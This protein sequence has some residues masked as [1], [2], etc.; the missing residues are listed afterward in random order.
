MDNIMCLHILLFFINMTQIMILEI[1][2]Y[3][4]DLSI[5]KF[6]STQRIAP[7]Y[8]PNQN[9]PQAENSSTFSFRLSADKSQKDI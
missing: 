5:F 7:S 6:L 1:Q 9:I 3:K 8:K 4:L 2:A